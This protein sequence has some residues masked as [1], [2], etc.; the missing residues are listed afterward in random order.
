MI[1][2]ML[3]AAYG[4]S[5]R[6]WGPPGGQVRASPGLRFIPTCVGTTSEKRWHPE[7]YS[8]HPH[9]RGDHSRRCQS[10][11]VAVE[12]SGNIP[13]LH[14]AI[15]AT[16]FGG[17]VCVVSFYGRDAAGLLLGEEFDIN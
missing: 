9:V 4:S 12:T 10:A 16:R 7:W 14:Q 6:A 3:V 8:V 13:A 17:T 5:P 15:R 2:L 11:A 1:L